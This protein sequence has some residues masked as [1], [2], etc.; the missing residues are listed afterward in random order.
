MRLAHEV[1]D[2]FEGTRH[3]PRPETVRAVLGLALMMA[4]SELLVRS[5]SALAGR[6]GVGQEFIGLTVVAVGTSA[7]VVAIA[8]QAARRGD[9]DLVVGNVLGSNLFVALAG[10]S[11]VGFLHHGPAPGS[12]AGPVWMMAGIVLASWGFMARGSL[13]TRWEA[14]AL[15]AAYAATLL[16]APR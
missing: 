1:T 16:L 7:P 2:F 4:G 8:V 3:R 5:A 12:A 10:G 9:P 6:L 15:I 14:S 13:V 11:L